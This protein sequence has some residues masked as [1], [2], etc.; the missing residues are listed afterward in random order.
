MGQWRNAQDNITHSDILPGRDN[1]LRN[2]FRANVVC[3]RIVASTGFHINH[4]ED[5]KALGQHGHQRNQE[6]H[7]GRQEARRHT[8]YAEDRKRQ[9]ELRDRAEHRPQHEE[10]RFGD[11]S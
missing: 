8:V 9:T 6:R 3:A 1:V 5:T 2:R 10:R 7:S 11:R 4:T